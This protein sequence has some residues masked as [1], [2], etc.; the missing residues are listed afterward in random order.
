MTFP[1]PVIPP[2]TVSTPLPPLLLNVVPP[3]FTVRA[4][5]TVMELEL[6]FSVTPVT[7][8]PMADDIVTVPT[9]VLRIVP[10]LLS[11]PVDR[12]TVP[13]TRLAIV[14]LFVPVTPPV[15]VFVKP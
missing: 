9:F 14:R 15:N 11:A 4:P 12:L 7:L 2:D 10:A 6:V 13:L 5:E 8:E 1:V 3:E